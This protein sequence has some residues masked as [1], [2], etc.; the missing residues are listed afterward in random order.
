[1]IFKELTIKNFRSFENV[2]LELTNRNIIFGLNDIG[3]TNLLAAIRF[4][5]DSKFRSNGLVDSD[6]Y[7]KDI[8]KE[9]NII[10]KINISDDE[11][12]DDNKKIFTMMK[13]AI[14]SEAE[15]IYIQLKSVFDGE[16][17][18]GLPNLFWGVNKDNLEAIPS[19]QSFFEL[20]K[21][22]NVVYIDSSIK[23]ED[24][25]KKYSRELFKG[26]S[27]ISEKERNQLNVHIKNLNTS[28]GQLN[29]I[30]LFEK[31]LI[32][33]YKKFKDDKNFKVSIRSEVSG[34]K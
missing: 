10:L 17:L 25:F 1:M 30:K 5:L 28:V 13:G 3:K 7:N 20:D 23:L 15:D 29:T 31:D 33:E 26:E 18:I 6:F 24:T 12:N 9:I 19:S 2:K 11:D 22:F 8:N 16:S 34:V 27:S 21:Y 14:P 32:K 4:L